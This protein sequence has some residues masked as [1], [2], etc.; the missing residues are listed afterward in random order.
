MSPE[1]IIADN[2]KLLV[3]SPLPVVYTSTHGRPLKCPTALRGLERSN[4]LR[5]CNLRADH[6]SSSDVRS[7]TYPRTAKTLNYEN[8]Q[9]H[10]DRSLSYVR[11]CVP[12]RVVTSSLVT[13]ADAPAQTPTAR[14]GMSAE[15]P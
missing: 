4:S 9:V 11:K 12:V 15:I 5:V 3:V 14:V 10:S 7:D 6:A 13:S 8:L 1:I 2:K